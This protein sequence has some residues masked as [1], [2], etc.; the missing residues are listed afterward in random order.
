MHTFETP[1][2]TTLVVRPAAGHVTVTAEE[3][4]RTTVELTPLNSAGEHAVARPR[5]S[6]SGGHRRHVP[7]RRG[8]LFRRAPGR[9]RDHLPDRH[10][11][12][13]EGRLRRRAG[14]RHLRRAVGPTGSG[15][16]EVED[17]TG[18]AKL[19]TGSGAVAAGQ[20]DEALLVATGS[21]NVD[22]DQ[23]GRHATLT[24]GSGDISIGELAGDVVTKTGSGD[25]EVGRLDGTLLDQDRVRRPDRAPRRA[26]AVRANGASGTINI[27]IERGHRGLAGRVHGQRPGQ[28][29]ARR[30]RRPARRPAARRDHRPHRERQPPGAPVMSRRRRSA[31]PSAGPGTPTPDPADVRCRT[32]APRDPRGPASPLSEVARTGL[33][34]G[35][36]PLGGG[37]VVRPRCRPSSSR[38]GRRRRPR[39]S[40]SA[41][42]PPAPDR[43][44]RPPRAAST[45]PGRRGRRRTPRGAY[46]P[47][48]RAVAAS[49]TSPPPWKPPTAAT[50]GSRLAARTA[51]RAPMQ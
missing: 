25:V 26:G 38:G 31:P 36:V 21:G 40:R 15:D 49:V 12:R 2:P 46:E 6:S 7:R 45:G 27:G 1:D 48:V 22:V 33:E 19:K 32:R 8:G 51:S 28:P 17:V 10:H 35:E 47:P 24:V 14:H 5:S 20:V 3:T 23:S 50:S 37:L 43:A 18:T 44:P 9:H 30:G 13:G 29:G 4:D 11:A 39:C 34:L 16:V 42:R 41:R